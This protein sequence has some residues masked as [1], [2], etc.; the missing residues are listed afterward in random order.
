MNKG[1]KAGG[2]SSANGAAVA[3]LALVLCLPSAWARGQHTNP[4]PTR[5][6]PRSQPAPRPQSAPKPQNQNRP[7][8]QRPQ[9]YPA[10]RPAPNYP[11]TVGPRPGYPNPSYPNPGYPSPGHPTQGYPNSGNRP[12][13][14]PGAYPGRTNPGSTPPGHLGAWLNEHRGLPPQEQERM[15]RGD[16]SFNRLPPGDQQRLLQQLHQVNQMPEQER[17][18]RL[19]RNEMLE[20]LSPQDRMQANLA[21]RSWAALPPGRQGMMKRAFQDLRAVPVEQRQTVLN[22]AR[23][24]GA[25]SPQE[26]GILSDLLRAEPYQ[27]AR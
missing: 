13:G 17:D 16:P 22:S 19:A 14:Y 23:Y 7:P 12:G 2:I 20:R 5:P 21:M 27:P 25:F 4:P 10:A 1:L 11:T 3:A 26:R 15:L 6:A 24:Q 9:N 8:Q 18:R